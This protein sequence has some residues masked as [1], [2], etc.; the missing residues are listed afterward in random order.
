[1]GELDY[2]MESRPNSRFCYACLQ[3]ADNYSVHQKI[4]GAGQ[5]PSRD[6]EES[7]RSWP[8]Q[9]LQETDKEDGDLC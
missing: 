2:F 6:A 5:R 1:M 7:R 4:I 8:R 3:E 9:S